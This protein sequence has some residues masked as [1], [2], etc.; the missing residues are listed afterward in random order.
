MPGAALQGPGNKVLSAIAMTS[1]AQRPIPITSGMRKPSGRPW[2]TRRPDLRNA[3]C[4]CVSQLADTLKPEHAEA[5][6]RVEVEGLSVQAFATAAG[7]SAN[8]AAVRLFR[9]REALRKRVLRSCGSCAE[10]CCL[11]CTCG[12]PRRKDEQGGAP[13]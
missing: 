3:V 12:A 5:L 2:E 10:H 6:H 8:S 11:D 7:I 1:T 9:A 4:R 13:A